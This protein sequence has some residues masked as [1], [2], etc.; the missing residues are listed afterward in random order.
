VCSSDLSLLILGVQPALMLIS[1][2]IMAALCWGITSI[3]LILGIRE[4][5]FSIKEP[6][7]FALSYKGFLCLVWEFLFT[8]LVI[9]LVGVPTALFLGKGA[10]F[11]FACSVSISLIVTFV[12]FKI[13]CN[14]YSAS[15]ARLSKAE[16]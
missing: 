4:A 13:L 1:M 3:C 12:I 10:S 5:D 2:L 6:L 15:L 14:L 7:D 16:L 11:Y 8:A 9:V